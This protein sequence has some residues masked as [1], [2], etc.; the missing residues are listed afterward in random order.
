MSGD[1]GVIFDRIP[2]ICEISIATGV[3][4]TQITE[5]TPELLQVVNFFRTK[6]FGD[7]CEIL[8]LCDK[9]CGINDESNKIVLSLLY[10]LI[11]VVG[12]DNKKLL[13]I[14]IVFGK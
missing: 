14:Y 12:T 3:S 1:D 6:N 4:L 7:V 5:E 8:L 11:V 10:L 9:Y 13:T 2:V